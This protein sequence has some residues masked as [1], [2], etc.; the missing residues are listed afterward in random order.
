MQR[1]LEEAVFLSRLKHL[2]I[3]QF[4][5]LYEE[6]RDEINMLFIISPW[7]HNGGIK[8][9][10]DTLVENKREIP[11]IRWVS[12]TVS[13]CKLSTYLFRARFARSPAVSG[14]CMTNV[15]FTG[16]FMMC[17]ATVVFF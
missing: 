13:F 8:N 15:S 14:T 5:G 4:I 7:I 12:H 3:V 6:K 11:R 10:M 1:L 9:Y 2:H 16:G 17:V